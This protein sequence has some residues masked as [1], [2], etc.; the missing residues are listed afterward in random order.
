[1]YVRYQI[2]SKIV[3]VNF[4]GCSYRD[5]RDILCLPVSVSCRIPTG[6]CLYLARLAGIALLALS[7]AYMFL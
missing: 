1:M 3:A 4:A 5:G 7:I 6:V 2:L